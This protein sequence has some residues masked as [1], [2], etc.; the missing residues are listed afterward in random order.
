M[1]ADHSIGRTREWRI[2]M[3][4]ES[5]HGEGWHPHY[6]VRSGEDG[7]YVGL[8][9]V[10]V[11]GESAISTLAD[12]LHDIQKRS[13]LTMRQL[14]K[15]LG[16]SRHTLYLWANGGSI[17][18]GH[19][20][21]LVKFDALVREHDTSDPASTRLALLRMTD[22]G[23]SAYDQFRIDRDGDNPEITD[24]PL[25]AADLLVGNRYDG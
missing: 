10:P 11:L 16:V 9:D 14:A 5:K 22:D 18:A 3:A 1:R 21:R 15:A 7:E 4:G 20:E 13:G 24:F 12:L 19:T 2:I 6:C 25:M 8:V 17:S 23:V